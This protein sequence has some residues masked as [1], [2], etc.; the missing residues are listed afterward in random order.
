MAS[1]GHKSREALRTVLKTGSDEWGREVRPGGWA[2]VQE[3]ALEDSDGHNA[4]RTASTP[5]I[6]ISANSSGISYFPQ[7]AHSIAS[8]SWLRVIAPAAR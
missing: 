2:P 7:G 8:Q 4:G 6:V 5:L 1:K 3:V